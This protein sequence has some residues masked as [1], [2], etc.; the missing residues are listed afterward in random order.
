MF[1]F[2]LAVYYLRFCLAT[3]VIK[4]LYTMVELATVIV[5]VY[6]IVLKVTRESKNTLT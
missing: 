2:F 1:Y 6:F 5:K 3:G 4:I